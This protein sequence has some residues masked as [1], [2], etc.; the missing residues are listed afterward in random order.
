MEL[1]IDD[2][3]LMGTL[4]ILE[5]TT[6][7]RGSV[8]A[9]GNCRVEGNLRTLMSDTRFQGWGFID[10]QGISLHL[11]TEEGAFLLKGAKVE[12]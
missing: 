4:F 8:D 11:F 7:V 12:A 2:G 1:D 5:Q 3:R 9:T 10:E 6:E